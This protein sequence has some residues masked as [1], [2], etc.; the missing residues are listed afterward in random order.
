MGWRCI[1]G[2]MNGKVN[3][4]C[5]HCERPEPLNKTV[6]P[7]KAKAYLNEGPIETLNNLNPDK[8]HLEFLERNDLIVTPEGTYAKRDPDVHVCGRCGQTGHNQKG[9]RLEPFP[10]PEPEPEIIEDPDPS[11]RKKRGADVCKKCGEEGHREKTC[12]VQKAQCPLCKRYGHTKKTCGRKR[13]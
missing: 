13:K 3:D 7:T 9:C 4:I 1:C 8:H 12:T 5:F 11:P 10:I 2:A 6:T